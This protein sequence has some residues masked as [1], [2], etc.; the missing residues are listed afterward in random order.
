[1]VPGV[2]CRVVSCGAAE[3]VRLPPARVQLQ[4][5][6]TCVV[7]ARKNA[8]VR[9]SA[10][11]ARRFSAATS[12]RTARAGCLT[13]VWAVPCCACACAD[14]RPA[15]PVHPGL[16]CGAGPREREATRGTIL[17]ICMRCVAGD[18]AAERRFSY[19]YTNL[20]FRIYLGI[21]TSYMVMDCSVILM[22]EHEHDLF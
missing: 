13:P 8:A 11:R 12:G 3:M 9:R 21:P 5:R 14:C 19:Y 20:A 18:A 10:R 6:H 7:G 16:G 2:G 15:C 22:P 4:G 1:M 17:C